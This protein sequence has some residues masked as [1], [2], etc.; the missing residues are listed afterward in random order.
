MTEKLDCFKR[1]RRC[2]G[3]LPRRN[4]LRIGAAGMTIPELLRAQATVAGAAEAAAANKSMIV[5]WLW[6]GPSHLET[7]DLKA[8]D[9]T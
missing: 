4:F 8:I 6:G 2:P 9:P 7:F 3:T 1:F 5:L